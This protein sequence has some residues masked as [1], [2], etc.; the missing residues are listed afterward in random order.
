MKTSSKL[1]KNGSIREKHL[2]FGSNGFKLRG[3][4]LLPPTASREKPVPGAVVCHGF[5]SSYRQ[6]RPAARMLAERGIATL[7]FDM[8][9]HCSSDGV[10]DGKMTEDILD[11]WQILKDYP[12]VDE[13][14]IGLAGHSL[15]ALYTI[16]AAESVQP[17]ALAALSCPPQ[18]SHCMLFE[19]PDNFGRW[20]R[21]SSHVIEYPGGGAFP[22]LTGLAAWGCRAWMYLFGYSARVDLRKFFTS[23]LQVNIKNILAGLKDCPKLFVFCSG[24]GITPYEKFAPVYEVAS[25]PKSL[26]LSRGGLHTTP[27]MKGQLCQSWVDWLALELKK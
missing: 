7:I 10:V 6:V 19:I 9:G 21:E 26:I 8:R 5:G 16:A 23:V 17:R 1:E 12:E 22:W 25:G 27:I 15:G 14:R 13:A 3:Q 11:A 2:T 24:D 20:G 4:I 18:L